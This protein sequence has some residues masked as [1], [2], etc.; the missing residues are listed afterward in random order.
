MSAAVTQP[1]RWYD[2]LT[3]SVEY[4][5]RLEEKI[6]EKPR[7]P[8]KSMHTKLVFRSFTH[9]VEALRA[10]LPSASRG[11]VSDL[12]TYALLLLEPNSA[13]LSAFPAVRATADDHD[14]ELTEADGGLTG[15]REAVEDLTRVSKKVSYDVNK[16]GVKVAVLTF[17]KSA[18][19]LGETVLGVVELNDRGGRARILKASIHRV[20]RHLGPYVTDR[21]F[22]FSLSDLLPSHNTAFGHARSARI[23]SVRNCGLS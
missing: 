10:S 17:V 4:G 20:A 14:Q 2:L 8:P 6:E 16:D 1:P 21:S 23:S 18:W 22:F 15:C 11:S 19:R 12:R 5:E 9:I 3:G 7:G 13:A